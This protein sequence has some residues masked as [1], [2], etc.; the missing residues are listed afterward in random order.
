MFKCHIFVKWSPHQV[1]KSVKTPDYLAVLNYAAA[2][3]LQWSSI[4]V[5]LHF[6]QIS[7]LSKIKKMVITVPS[8]LASILP[9]AMAL[10][11]PSKIVNT[12]PSA[13]VALFV[14]FMS[15]KSRIFSPLDNSRPKPS[16]QDPT[17]RDRLRPSWTPPPLAFPIIWSS[18]AVLRTIATVMIFQTT[19]TLLCTPIFAFFGHLSIGDTWNTVNN[20][21]KRLGTAVL[22]VSFV[23][24]S[25]LITTY[26]YY[27]TN[28]GAG[29]ILFPM[30]IW[31]S[32]ASLLVYS[33]WK[34]NSK[35]LN[36]RP[37]LFPSIEEGPRSA[38]R[39]PFTTKK[40]T[41]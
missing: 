5:F 21:E 7:I 29:K 28:I 25:A 23:W 4:A 36:D 12:V 38:W 20:V 1:T 35:Y 17:F 6:F 10:E 24:L 41:A 22:G 3:S 39:I 9:P 2:T 34:L 16:N 30:N 31:L 33:I 32:V 11:L 40:L 15:L 37:S 19:G 18:I 26:L 14:L 8:I 13:L 27:K